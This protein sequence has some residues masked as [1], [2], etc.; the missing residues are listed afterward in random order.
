MD[1]SISGRVSKRANDRTSPNTTEISRSAGRRVLAGEGAPDASLG[2]ASA[3]AIPTTI[4]G[5]GSGEGSDER[6][7][8]GIDGGGTASTNRGSGSEAGS[9]AGLSRGTAAETGSDCAGTVQ[10]SSPRSSSIVC[11]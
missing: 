10:A 5:I 6:S 4:G 9:A 3:S 8:S 7:G 11:K 2:A 1:A